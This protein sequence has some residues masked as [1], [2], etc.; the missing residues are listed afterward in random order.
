MYRLTKQDV[1]LV[2]KL[3]D[4]G[5]PIYFSAHVIFGLSYEQFADRAK[6]VK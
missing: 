3:K 4:E 5:V 1:K 6:R 2:Y